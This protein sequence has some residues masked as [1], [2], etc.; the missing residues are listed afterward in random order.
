MAKILVAEDE[1]DIRELIRLTLEYDGY[2]AAGAKNGVEAVELAQ[3]DRFDLILLDVRM[4]RMGGLEACRALRQL[5]ATRTVPIIFISAKG[6]GADVQA[7]L[8]AGGT[9]YLLKP[10]APADL[11]S[12]VQEALAG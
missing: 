12:R 11:L 5:E 2:Q 3:R 9:R 4:P 8:T 7:G 1:E 6:Q 10:F